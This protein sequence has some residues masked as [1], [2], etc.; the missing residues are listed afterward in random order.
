[1]TKVTTVVISVIIAIRYRGIGVNV[2]I[3]D[4]F[5]RISSGIFDSH[6]T[7]AVLVFN[8]LYTI[9]LSKMFRAV[10]FLI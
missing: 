10:F 8:I 1:M 4:Y 9:H 6:N 7:Y 2:I 3:S 5:H